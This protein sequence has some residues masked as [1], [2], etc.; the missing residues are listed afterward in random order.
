MMPHRARGVEGE[1]QGA[2]Q[3]QQPPRPAKRL[4]V[5]AVQ[6]QEPHSGEQPDEQPDDADGDA[7]LAAGAPAGGLAACE[8]SQ[9]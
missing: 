9:R 1:R 4:V 8:G 2:A 7:G 3:A 6:R 5:V